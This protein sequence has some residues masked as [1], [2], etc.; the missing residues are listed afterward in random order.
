MCLLLAVCAGNYLVS[1]EKQA[2]GPVAMATPTQSSGQTD[3]Q[4]TEEVISYFCK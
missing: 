2:N 1:T 4:L 3:K